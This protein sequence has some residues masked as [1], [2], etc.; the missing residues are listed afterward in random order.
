M[1]TLKDKCFAHKLCSLQSLLSQ[2]E[3]LFNIQKCIQK[4]TLNKRLCKSHWDSFP[5][6]GLVPLNFSMS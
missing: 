4:Y 6:G 2:R 3:T 5:G 1:L